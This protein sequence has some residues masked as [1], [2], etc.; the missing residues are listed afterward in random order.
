MNGERPGFWHRR[1][2]LRSHQMARSPALHY[3]SL[4]VSLSPSLAI[5]Y[6]LSSLLPASLSSF[7]IVCPDR[8]NIFPHGCLRGPIFPSRFSG[9]DGVI[10]RRCPPAGLAG[11][12]TA[13]DGL[14]ATSLPFP[15]LPLPRRPAVW[16]QW[17][18]QAQ[19]K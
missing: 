6:G 18:S 5:L 14:M 11:L 9:S 3:C 13:Q 2:L 17:S 19:S 16:T 15:A 12:Y 7:V 1:S 8:H 10:A 4:F